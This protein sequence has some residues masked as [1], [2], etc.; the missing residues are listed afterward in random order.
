MREHIAFFMY[1]FLICKV[2]FNMLAIV[3]IK[4]EK[5]KKLSMELQSYRNVFF[6]KVKMPKYRNK[7]NIKQ[8]AIILKEK[9]VHAVICNT[10][11]L[12]GIFLLPDYSEYI[13]LRQADIVS[14]YLKNHNGSSVYIDTYYN[15]RYLKRVVEKCAEFTSGIYLSESEAAEIILDEFMKNSGITFLVTKKP[16]ANAVLVPFKEYGAFEILIPEPYS[17][18]KPQNIPSWRFAG[19]V[20][21]CTRDKNVTIWPV[22]CH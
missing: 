17:L 10:K 14:A 20:W 3:N 15:R 22:I 21:E 11:H 5:I 4:V 16:P 9:N 13:R 18:Y 19:M 7:R 6:V 8:L 12:D 2:Y 1:N